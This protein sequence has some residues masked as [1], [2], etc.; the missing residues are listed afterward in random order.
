MPAGTGR[1]GREVGKRGILNKLRSL[2]TDTLYRIGNTGL[3][4]FQALLF[5]AANFFAN[6]SGWWGK[7]SWPEA[8]GISFVY[9]VLFFSVLLA[10]YLSVSKEEKE[11]PRW[12]Y[13]LFIVA[14]V[15]ALPTIVEALPCFDQAD[16]SWWKAIK[17][18]IGTGCQGA[19]GY[20]AWK[21]AELIPA[22]SAEHSKGSA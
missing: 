19:A 20:I 1:E 22:P 5:L 2:P 13:S 11:P 15:A 17:L 12:M 10:Y 6:F 16:S 14:V 4:L 9:V 7:R 8:A 3:I 18:F 21:A